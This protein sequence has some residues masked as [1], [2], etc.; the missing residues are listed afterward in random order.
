MLE[1]IQKTSK[2]VFMLIGLVLGGLY[3]VNGMN[4]LNLLDSGI[5]NKKIELNALEESIKAAQKIA[6]DK[7]KFEEE[8]Q[9]I[10]DLLKAAVEF[11][12]NKINEQEVLAKISNEARSA[13][14]NLTK[15][16]PNKAQQK[17]FYE[18]L[19]M[20]IE[21]E[22]SYTQLVL[23]LSYI[24]KIQ[25]I[26]NIKGLELRLKTY[27]DEISILKVRGTVVAYRYVENVDKP[28]DKLLETPK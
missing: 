12:P 8:N 28:A 23:F 15:V 9:K 22:G 2:F 25:R 18:E 13:G 17:G 27:I 20:D 26:V 4:N 1:M 19:Q 16:Q 6:N 21:M 24:S 11:L 14:V 7:A 5:A 10:S 3:Y